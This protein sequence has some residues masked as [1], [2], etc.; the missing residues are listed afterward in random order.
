MYISTK[1]ILI[2]DYPRAPGCLALAVTM[3]KALRLLLEL[4]ELLCIE[5]QCHDDYWQS[6]KWPKLDACAQVQER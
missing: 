5:T 1:S 2:F 4:L 6:Q 3:Q